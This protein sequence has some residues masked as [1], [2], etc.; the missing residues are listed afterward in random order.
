MFFLFTVDLDS[1]V[2]QSRSCNSDFYLTIKDYQDYGPTHL[3]G[4]KFLWQLQFT[5]DGF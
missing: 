4:L 2:L 3:P 5:L 1:L